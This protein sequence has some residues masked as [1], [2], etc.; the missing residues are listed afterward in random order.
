[1]SYSVAPYMCKS[2]ALEA[3]IP[4]EQEQYT[5]GLGFSERQKATQRLINKINLDRENYIA[6]LVLNSANLATSNYLAL[7]GTS[8]WDNYTGVSHPILVIDQAKAQLR[9]SGIQDTDMVLILSDP[10]YVALQ[11]HP[12]MIERFKY[13]NAGGNIG[14]DQMSSV[15]RVK[16]VLASAISLSNTN[17][18]SFVWGQSA[19]LCHAQNAT[20]QQDISALKTF[21]WT[22]APDSVDGYG[23]IEFPNPHLSAK[24]TIVS[25]DWYWDTR[26]TAQETIFVIANTCAAPTMEAIAPPVEG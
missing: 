11:N 21:V 7:A 25:V 12:D 15:F 14:L 19:V 5:L 4:F 2:H 3:V 18:A 23:V 17:V 1:M 22:A 8:M 16:V 24:S 26:V 10:T 20:S 9:Q 13:T 6:Q